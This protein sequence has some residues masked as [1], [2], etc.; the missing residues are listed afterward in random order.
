MN[1]IIASLVFTYGASYIL[2]RTVE[3]AAGALVTKTGEYVG[4]K[5][6]SSAKS[7]WNYVVPQKDK[8]LD[9]EYEYIDLDSDIVKYVRSRRKESI[10]ENW[11]E[12]SQELVEVK[13]REN[14]RR[15]RIKPSPRYTSIPLEDICTFETDADKMLPLD[16]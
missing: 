12:M 13:H 4:E 11:D 8:P 3:Y 1:Q 7:A 6:S 15:Q 2:Q 9:I 10:D 5:V 14:I 16:I